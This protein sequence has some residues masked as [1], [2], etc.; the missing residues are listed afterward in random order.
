MDILTSLPVHRDNHVLFDDAPITSSSTT[1]SS[2]HGNNYMRPSGNNGR[3]SPLDIR[4]T[5]ILGDFLS[6]NIGTKAS[7]VGINLG[8]RGYNPDAY[9]GEIS[10]IYANVRAYDPEIFPND[11]ALTSASNH[12]ITHDFVS[13]LYRLNKNYCPNH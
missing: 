12:T 9:Y 1:S 11:S 10:R 4:D 13:R 3:G 6:C 7:K 8:A 5:T 2:T